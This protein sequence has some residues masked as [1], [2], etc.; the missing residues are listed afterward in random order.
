[1]AVLS[2]GQHAVTAS[3]QH[4]VV[5]LLQD[6]LFPGM[7]GRV[8]WRF[9]GVASALSDRQYA[10]S[11]SCASRSSWREKMPQDRLGETRALTAERPPSCLCPDVGL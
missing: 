5:I 10:P 7:L 9:L 2:N 6:A 8:L 11:I 4:F 3:A 1:M